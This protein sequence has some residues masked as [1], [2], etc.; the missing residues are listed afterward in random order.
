MKC[1]SIIIA[2]RMQCKKF[3]TIVPH[4]CATTMKLTKENADF[5]FTVMTELSEY[6]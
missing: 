5:M 6:A 4:Y 1:A 3:E 2:T